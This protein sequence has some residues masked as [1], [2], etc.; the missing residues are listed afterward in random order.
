MFSS[1][2]AKELRTFGRLLHV[3]GGLP[4][5]VVVIVLATRQQESFIGA[6]KHR[7]QKIAGLERALREADATRES[8]G[9]VQSALAD[10]R[11]RAQEL[12]E[13]I[14]DDPNEA[15]Y[16]RQLTEVAARS[17]LS[18]DDYSRGLAV[19]TESFSQLKVRLQGA[20]QYEEICRFLDRLEQLPRVSRIVEMKLT[21]EPGSLS[22]PIDLTIQLYFGVKSAK[23][24]PGRG[25]NG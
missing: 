10:F 2:H 25:A 16:L 14:P 3:A 11:R 15:D 20:G 23:P 1:N 5:V 8:H 17:N 4:V 24:L 19:E 18:I 7:E 9:E 12:R 6:V 22:Y 21:T 13:Q